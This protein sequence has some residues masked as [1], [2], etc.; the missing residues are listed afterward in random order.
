M[1]SLEE[2]ISLA[3]QVGDSRT[4]ILATAYLGLADR[5][6]EDRC[7]VAVVQAERLGDE[8]SLAMALNCLSMRFE[9]AAPDRATQ[10]AARSLEL[11]RTTGDHC[12]EIAALTN[13]GD[14]ALHSGRLTSA[15]PLLEHALELARSLT[16]QRYMGYAALDLAYVELLDGSD[17]RAR[18]LLRECLEICRSIGE[19]RLLAAA[20]TA[21]AGVAT[22]R[23]RAAMLVGAADANLAAHGATRLGGESRVLTLVE[24]RWRSGDPQSWETSRHDGSRLRPASTDQLASSELATVVEDER[25]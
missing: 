8:W 1:P 20:L 10:Y 3:R 16:Y 21:V 9:E 15:R 6:Q 13:L 14:M 18:E 5:G 11:I 19:P 7:Q 25:R 23:T 24:D 4:E 12:G 2:A 17:D 22:T